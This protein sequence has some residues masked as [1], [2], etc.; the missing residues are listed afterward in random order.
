MLYWNLY[1]GVGHNADIRGKRKFYD[2]NIYTFDIETSSYF[3]LNGKVY[4]A[5]KYDNLSDKEKE[6]CIKRSHMY[7]WMFGINDKVY[8]GRSD[9]DEN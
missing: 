3:E 9:I 1:N 7:I 5:I 6:K 4:T 2:A 8:Y